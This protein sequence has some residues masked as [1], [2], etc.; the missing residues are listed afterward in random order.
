MRKCSISDCKIR[1]LLLKNHPGGLKK[2]LSLTLFY[3][4]YYYIMSLRSDMT[5]RLYGINNQMTVFF[6]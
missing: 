3:N 5:F 2:C 1:Q 6:Y 4:S